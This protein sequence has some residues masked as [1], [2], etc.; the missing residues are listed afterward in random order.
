MSSTS[1]G[2][3]LPN[4]HVS[5]SRRTRNN[6]HGEGSEFDIQRRLA[7]YLDETFPNVLW[8]ASVGGARTSMREAIRL[9]ETGYKKGFPDLFIYEPRGD[10]HGLAIE[11]KKDSGGRVS[12][13]QK[14]WQQ[15]LEMRGYKATVAKG[16][17]EAVRVLEWYLD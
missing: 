7:E 17:A 14:E 13:S 16:Y 4:K 6:R 5:R 9:K 12:P 11:L 8:C 15:A 2:Q 3:P 10:H 1:G